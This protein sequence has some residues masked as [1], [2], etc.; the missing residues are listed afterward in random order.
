[1]DGRGFEIG[2]SKLYIWLDDWR[3]K[4]LLANDVLLLTTYWP[5]IPKRSNIVEFRIPKS[6]KLKGLRAAKFILS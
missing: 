2:T 5:V 4:K 6:P 1:M 3:L